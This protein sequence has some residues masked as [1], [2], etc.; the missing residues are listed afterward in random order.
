MNIIRISKAIW[1]KGTSCIRHL[2]CS[3]C[4]GKCFFWVCFSVLTFS[5]WFHPKANHPLSEFGFDKW[6]EGIM[7]SDL[8]YR[9]HYQS[10]SLFLKCVTPPMISELYKQPMH[11]IY[12]VLPSLFSDGK[13]FQEPFFGTYT[14]NIVIHRYIYA[15]AA[16]VLPVSNAQLLKVLHFL[17]CVLLG[18]SMAM[19]FYWL[20]SKTSYGVMYLLLLLISGTSPLFPCAQNLYWAAWSLFLPMSVMATVVNHPAFL[21]ISLRRKVL[22][23]SF[24]AFATL[25]LKQL[26]YFELISSV[27][28]AMMLPVIWFLME[29]P[30]ATR[31]E[32]IALLFS[33]AI[34]AIL[35]FAFCL[36]VK[37]WM[38]TVEKGERA[39]EIVWKNLAMRLFNGGQM[40]EN[41]LI[42]ESANAS[43]FQVLND[44]SQKSILV[45]TLTGPV[46]VRVCLL[47][48]ILITIKRIYCGYRG[49]L[50]I[51]TSLRFPSV[52]FGR[53][54]SLLICTWI[55]LLAPLSW[56]V[57][58]KPHTYIHEVQCSILW[59]LPFTILF[60]TVLIDDFLKSCRR[61]S[62]I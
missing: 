4:K 36:G 32:R 26:M 11:E 23:L 44:M 10:S 3:L 47:L 34:S 52:P 18:F 30:S 55:S 49:H 56:F 16:R 54:S 39:V 17:N 24:V 1:Q 37:F 27:M 48:L 15:L 33:P 2:R 41:P 61:T 35:A 19:L 14:S 20:K 5:M 45:G 40:S 62:E 21:G 58:A 53:E 38:L 50:P 51:S 60:L 59:F 7:I 28:I 13:T 43:Y 12:D 6:S 9:Q 31:R 22:I 42:A 25:T 46:T 29:Q 8:M 57:L